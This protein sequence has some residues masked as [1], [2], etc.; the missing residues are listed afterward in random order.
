MA[1]VANKGSCRGHAKARGN[2]DKHAAKQ[3]EG[4][5]VEWH[6][7]RAGATPK[8]RNGCRESRPARRRSP[9]EPGEPGMA[10]KPGPPKMSRRRE[11]PMPTPAGAGPSGPKWLWRRR[12]QVP[13]RHGAHRMPERPAPGSEPPNDSREDARRQSASCTKAAVGSKTRLQPHGR[14]TRQKWTTPGRRQRPA[15]YVHGERREDEERNGESRR[16]TGEI[17]DREEE[18]RRGSV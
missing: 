12:D 9:R 7:E 13:M 17:E 5:R 3:G 11:R 18:D 6:G 10:E 2:G 14:S 1:A 4:R 16:K 15:G 8:G